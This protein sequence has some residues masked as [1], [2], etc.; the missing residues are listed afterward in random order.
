MTLPALILLLACRQ[1]A[2]DPGDTAE[3]TGGFDTGTA[4][5]PTTPSATMAGCEDR[6]QAFIA[7]LQADF[8][9]AD[10]LGASIALMED[11]EP[12]CR[13]T[14]GRRRHDADAPPDLDTLFQIGSTTKMFTSLALL[15]GVQAGRFSL[16]DSLAAALPESEFALDPSWNDQILLRHL[17]THEGGFYDYFDWSAGSED[18]D[19]AAWHAEVFFPYLWL[20]NE[21][22]AFWNYSNPNF[23]LAGL[24]VEHHDGRPFPDLMAEDVFGPLGMPRTTMRLA[25]AVADGN[26]AEGTGYYLRRGSFEYGDVTVDRI[27]DPAHARPAG[28][29]TWTT[30]TQVLRM[31]R[32][33]M[34]GDEAIL[35][36]DLRRAMSTPQVALAMG[37]QPS[38]YGY[39]LMVHEGFQLGE[40]WYALPL[41]EHG[42]NTLSYSSELYIVPEQGFALSILTSGY[43][44]SLTGGA[45]Q[46]FLDFVELP[47]PSPAPVWEVDPE[48]LDRHVGTYEDAYNVGE[49]IVWR[50]GDGLHISMPFLESLGYVVGEELVPLSSDLWLLD[51]DGVQYD[52][53]FIAREGEEQSTWIRNRAFV[54]TRIEDAPEGPPPPVGPLRLA[55]GRY[56]PHAISFGRP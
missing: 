9:R 23:D 52:L 22:G 29:G 41:W 12:T 21:P 14:L 8:A 16:D 24:L 48:R 38:S 35:R 2:V 7:A 4:T 10:A 11:G 40:D 45:L 25:E 34:E 13:L 37:P 31:A 3:D 30:P 33:L 51:L 27:P 17:L 54:G 5:S 26:L 32:F 55:H 19:L 49:M 50:E 47:A 18:E 36:D 56:Q 20:M 46:A 1:K 43:G 44:Q 28:A 15:Q 6:H 42:G 53:T 39:G